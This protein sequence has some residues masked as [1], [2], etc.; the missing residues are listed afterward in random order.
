MLDPKKREQMVKERSKKSA[1][2]RTITDIM[3]RSKE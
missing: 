3:H 1:Q 2:L